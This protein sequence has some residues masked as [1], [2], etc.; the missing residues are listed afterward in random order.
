MAFDPE[1]VEAEQLA[2]A[3][4]RV[5]A[6]GAEPV[7]AD[8]PTT[9]LTID[10]EEFTPAGGEPSPHF[11]KTIV[12]YALD[13]AVSWYPEVTALKNLHVVSSVLWAL[14]ERAEAAGGGNRTLIDIPALPGNVS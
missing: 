13:E 4:E 7:V 2:A 11:A 9:I 10:L 8:A 1:R 6:T 5:A 3:R 14:G 12:W